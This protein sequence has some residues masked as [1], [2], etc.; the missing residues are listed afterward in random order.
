MHDENMAV[1]PLVADDLD[2]VV[3]LA[4]RRGEQRQP[5]APRLWRR[6]R[7]A[8]RV[9][10]RYLGSLIADPAVPAMRTD[11]TFAFGMPRPGLVLVDDAA[12]DRADQWA[13][14]GAALVRRLVGGSRVRFV[15][16]VP[17][18]ERAALAVQLGLSCAETW[19]HRDLTERPV[20]LRTDESLQ[21]RGAQGRLIAAP[22]VY[23]P[24]GPVLLVTQ[25]HDRRALSEIEREAASRG[26]TVSVVTQ[27]PE[28]SVREELLLTAGYRRTCDFYEGTLKAGRQ[29]SR[30]IFDDQ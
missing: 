16:P 3:D 22:P 9:H 10:A 24:G 1:R 4:T 28:D 25:F 12:A 30:S 19:W 11:H 18:P 27:A 21:V 6:A 7:D 13:T 23:A 29:T 8:R 26:A 15:C 20:D 5:F 14:E 17:E 2:W